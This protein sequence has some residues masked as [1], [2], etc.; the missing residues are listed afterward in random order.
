MSWVPLGVERVACMT[1]AYLKTSSRNLSN[2]VIVVIALTLC[3]FGI[4]E[5]ISL[6]SSTLVEESL[7]CIK[8]G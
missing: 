3:Q 8:V 6:V 5:G 2:E 4:C 7:C 1:A